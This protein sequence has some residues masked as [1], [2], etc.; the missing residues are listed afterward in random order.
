[1]LVFGSRGRQIILVISVIAV[2]STINATFLVTPRILYGMARDGLLPRGVA[3]V[4]KGGTPEMALFL[5]TLASVAL[6]LTGTFDT[7]IAIGSILFV[8][9]YMSGFVSLLALRKREPNLARPYRA[10]WYPW[11]TVGVLVASAA[12]LAGSVVEDP[13]HSLF[14]AVL[15][16]LSYVAAVFIVRRKERAAS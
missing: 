1:M 2:I 11:S 6:V 15:V 9:V 4:N 14:T 5:C 3:S 13:K 16:L 10:W 7:L 8:A 12:F